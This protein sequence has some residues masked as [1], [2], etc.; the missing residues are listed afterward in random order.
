M[1]GD[2]R[3]QQ[4]KFSEV[5]QGNGTPGQGS[6]IGDLP[7]VHFDRPDAILRR[8]EA[9]A[10]VS[11]DHQGNASDDRRA[12]YDGHQL[13]W[14]NDPPYAQCCEQA[15]GDGFAPAHQGGFGFG[16]DKCA[17]SGVQSGST[18]LMRY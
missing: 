6:E 2:G 4:G 7:F 14:S 11:D 15:P 12:A 8:A 17:H 9:C 1:G 3:A 18:K 10:L 5:T 13:P 16:A